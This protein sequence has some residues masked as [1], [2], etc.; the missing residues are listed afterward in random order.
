MVAAEPS[1]EIF[2]YLSTTDFGSDWT[3]YEQV[4]NAN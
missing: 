2:G 3:E 1:L 4:I